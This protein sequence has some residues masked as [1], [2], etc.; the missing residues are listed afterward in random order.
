MEK[1][2]KQI[3]VFAIFYAFL[4]IL[5][6]LAM[7]IE[8]SWTYLFTTL[9]AFVFSLTLYSASKDITKYRIPLTIAIAVLALAVVETLNTLL[10]GGGLFMAATSI[11]E[12]ILVFYVISLLNILR[13]EVIAKPESTK[14]NK[15]N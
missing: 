9:L 13:K 11:L 1:T 6:I 7:I 8:A 2:K 4:G 10:S 12:L 15:E 14:E 3:Q 5:N